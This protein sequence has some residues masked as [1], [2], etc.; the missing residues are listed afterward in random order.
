MA[1]PL[2]GSV[3]VQAVVTGQ[4]QRL[5][6]RRE[7]RLHREMLLAPSAEM[8]D[9]RVAQVPCNM[10]NQALAGLAEVQTTHV[11]RSTTLCAEML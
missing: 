8:S 1:V 5:R 4:L 2:F 9:S 6:Q 3:Q 10:W 7:M 11:T